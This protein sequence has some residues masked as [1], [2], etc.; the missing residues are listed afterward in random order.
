MKIIFFDKVLFEGTAEECEAYKQEWIKTL[1]R[2]DDELQDTYPMKQTDTNETY[3]EALKILNP[4]VHE[5][6]STIIERVGDYFVSLHFRSPMSLVTVSLRIYADLETKRTKMCALSFIYF[7][8]V[9]ELDVPT[10]W[11]IEE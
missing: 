6:I 2:L 11:R 1:G 10:I 5:T 4:Y 3:F 9:F 7:I 8:L